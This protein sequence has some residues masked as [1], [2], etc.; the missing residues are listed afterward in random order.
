MIFIN[1][2]ESPNARKYFLY[3]MGVIILLSI[4]SSIKSSLE[5]KSIKD[6]V[7]KLFYYFLYF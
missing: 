5:D 6:S 7:N 2:K 4:I 1:K 3:Y